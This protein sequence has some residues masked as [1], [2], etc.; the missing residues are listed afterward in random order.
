M[1]RF[2]AQLIRVDTCSAMRLQKLLR[3]SLL[4][5]T[6]LALLSVSA[7]SAEVLISV[8]KTTQHMTVS[9]DGAARYEWPVSTGRPGYNTPNGTFHPLSMNTMHHSKEFENAPMPDSIF[10][11]RGYAIHGYTHTPFGIAA[12]SHGCVRLPPTDAAALF[13]LVKENGMGDTTIVVSGHAPHRPLLA[14]RHTPE[15]EANISPYAQ[16]G[17]AQEGYA[18]EGYERPPAAAA[19]P[20]QYSEPPSAWQRPQIYDRG[21]PTYDSG[22]GYYPQQPGYYQQQSGYYQQ[23]YGGSYQRLSPPY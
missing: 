2:V 10:F 23:P 9:V 5:A 22:P 18:Q 15:Q 14:R 13:Q 17:Y 12:V 19:P 7:A 20:G 8:D 4:L 21:Q 1:P 16:E 3:S 6:G 11:T